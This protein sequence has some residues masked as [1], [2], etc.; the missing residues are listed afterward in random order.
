MPSPRSHRAGAAPDPVAAGPWPLC[1]RV[2]GCL[3][4]L[5]LGSALAPRPAAAAEATTLSP[6]AD[7]RLRQEILDGVY[8]FAPDPDRNWI[9]LRTRT[10]LRLDHGR[11][12]GE[13]LLTNEHRHYLTPGDVDFDWD[14]LILDQAFWSYQADSGLRLTVGRQNI[15]WP[16]GFL[17]LEGHPLDGSRSLYHNALRLQTP[18]GQA[19]VDLALIHNPQRDPLILAGDLDRAL[20]DADETALAVRLAHGRWVWSAILKAERGR[21]SH[22]AGD[23]ETV[24]VAGRRTSSPAVPVAWHVELA[25]QYQHGQIEPLPAV[26]QE[27]AIEA[28]PDG[29]AWAAD[30]AVKLPLVHDWQLSA[31][32]FCYSGL[33]GDQRPFRTPYGRWPKWSELYIYSLIGESRGGRVHVAA[34]EN[35][36][37][38]HLT[39]TRP[40]HRRLSVS[41]GATW[42]LAPEPSWQARGWLTQAELQATLGPRLQGHLRWEMLAPGRFHDG[43]HGLPP[44]TDTVHFLRWQLSYTL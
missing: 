36:A 42:L 39:V 14:E 23:L 12:R 10:G 21:D 9:R 13:I 3:A 5:W 25:L 44:L 34:W 18:A 28:G 33:D 43:R 27:P 29:W 6:L 1:L 8:H 4:L 2:L 15:I 24:T 26:D 32:A 30:L 19:A 17:M 37:A 7:V 38:P 20:S 16:G 31:G 22:L 40:L 35:I 41:L 11:H